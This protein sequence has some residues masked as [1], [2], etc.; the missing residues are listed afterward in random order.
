MKND[1]IYDDKIIV[2]VIFNNKFSWYITDKLLW[3]MDLKKMSQND[4]KEY[5]SNKKI[6]NI[7]EDIITLS[8][9]NIEIFLDKIIVYKVDITK[10]RLKI[11]SKIMNTNRENELE[12][13]YPVMLLDFDKK[14]LYSQY[15]EPFAFENYIPDNWEGKYTSFIDYIDDENKYWIYK[16]KN[17]FA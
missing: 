7:R 13:F 1:P 12:D 16:N 6:K 8:E 4:Y 10:L 5:F 11:L 14:I 3:I 15:P 17:F 2:G 9:K